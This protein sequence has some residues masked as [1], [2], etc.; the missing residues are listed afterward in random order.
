VG[1]PLPGVGFDDFVTQ[2]RLA[3]EAGASGYLAGRSVW[4]DAVTTVYPR[5]RAGAVEASRSRIERLNE[6]TRRYGQPYRPG[7]SLD[8]ALDRLSED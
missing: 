3:C 8:E 1:H 4:R 5:E 6:V 7:V 2:V